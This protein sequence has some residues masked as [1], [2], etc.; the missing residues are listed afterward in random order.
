MARTTEPALPP[1]GKD[2]DLPL[3]IYRVTLRETLRRFGKG[4]RQR[5]A[6]A[7]RLERIYRVSVGTGRLARF[8]VFGSFVSAKREPAD[9][10]VFLLMEDTFDMRQ[11]S[12]EARVL[13]DHAA[14]QA[15]FGASVF[16]LR[17]LA[18]LGGEE[19]AIAGWQIKR[20]GTCRGIIEIVEEQT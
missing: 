18:A 4:S 20:D 17:R 7:Q 12:G 5:F 11:L 2:G 6:V 3:G 13:F 1:L 15:Y 10:D 16:W 19:Q 14:A 8:V 9:V